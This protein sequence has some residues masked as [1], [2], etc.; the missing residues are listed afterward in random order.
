MRG[1]E[2]KGLASSFWERSDGFY[3]G[4]MASN[5]ECMLEMTGMTLVVLRCLM[6][7][8]IPLESELPKLE[9][10]SFVKDI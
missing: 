9:S 1:E 6:R 2:E 5:V 7:V 4:W 10:M 8:H 3:H